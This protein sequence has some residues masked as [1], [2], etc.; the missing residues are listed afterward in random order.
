[1]SKASEWGKQGAEVATG[2]A[3]LVC[4]VCGVRL[5]GKQKRWCCPAHKDTARQRRSKG[6]PV[7]DGFSFPPGATRGG[8]IGVVGVLLDQGLT[9]KEIAEETGQ[10]ES[11]VSRQVKKLLEW[12]GQSEAAKVWTEPARN[13][14][15][16]LW[17]LD[18]THVDAL[19]K[20]FMW[21]RDTF[22]QTERGRKWLT[23]PF[24]QKWV[25][26][27]I[28][29]L[30]RG[31]RL[32][33]LSPPRHGKTEL[34]IHTV[35]WLICRFPNIRIIWVGGNLPL[36]KQALSEVLEHLETDD[37]L[38]K[39]FCPP[40]ARFEPKKR[41]GRMWSSETLKVAT[42]TIRGM[43][44]PTLKAVGRGGRL[45]SQDTDFIICD[46]IED[47][48]STVAAV[49]REETRR[50]WTT[51]PDS[52]KEEHTALFYIGSRAHPDD[53]GGYLIENQAYDSIVEHAHDPACE[54]P[55]EE[56]ADHQECMLFPDIRSFKW[57][58][59][60]KLSA[61]T[62]GGQAVFDMLYQNLST[63]EG[64]DMFTAEVVHPSRSADHVV[65][66]IPSPLED[67]DPDASGIRLVAGLDPSGSGYQAAVLWAYQVRPEL[68]MW[69]VD[70]ENREGG[71]IA[72]ARKTIRK[73]HD[74][75]QV[76]HWVVEENLYQG[77]IVD[78]EKIREFANEKGI[79]LE[80]FRTYRNK[81][82]PR[83]GVTSM[84]PLFAS[85]AIT[86]PYGDGPS[87][88]KTDVYVRQLLHYDGLAPRNR[89]TRTGPKTDLVMA[90]WF[91]MDV[92]RR[93]QNEFISE[94]GVDYQ[95]EYESF[96]GYDWNE[97]P[98]ETETV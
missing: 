16:V 84:Q 75:Y 36:A 95:P 63:G 89:N 52:R 59:E 22:F 72:Q 43:K 32:I 62:V 66:R 37:G 31:G 53:L 97:V 48:K 3:A 80:S 21:V 44:Q 27:V 81:I 45:R 23:P 88:A 67:Q 10:T 34:L 86:L 12:R 29:N 68:H 69:L 35:V 5:V 76:S 41:Q 70:I 87:K 56:L 57:L 39:A 85:G 54:T 49:T 25:R 6:V 2:P 42:R 61:E 18:E 24:Q 90:S 93:A 19:V 55:V 60:Q 92:I 58:M 47:E 40:G 26:A 20:D 1:M 73:W 65:G 91:P 17:D 71:G 51:G 82:D 78:D 74:D 7:E 30:V 4:G 64:F 33:I 13:F 94:M 28:S 14:P 46:D 98:W 83:I 15:V 8:E 79:V 96:S 9:Q 77:G 50:W 11:H 38:I